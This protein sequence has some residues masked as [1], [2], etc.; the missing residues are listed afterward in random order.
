MN[1]AQ[2]LNEIRNAGG[3]VCVRNHKLMVQPMS[4]ISNALRKQISN[5]RDDL[6][7]VLQTA[8]NE[9]IDESVGKAWT[10]YEQRVT[11]TEVLRIMGHTYG[12]LNCTPDELDGWACALTLRTMQA[13]QVIPKGW[14]RIANCKRC[15][16]VWSEH[17]LPTLSCGWCWM[18][19]KG[20]PFPQPDK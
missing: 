12:V 16:K 8:I 13:R 6:Y 18:R 5:N 10:L 14:S 19:V 1:A 15:G 9:L 4:V 17:D 7:T 11:R 2:V 3:S 20:L